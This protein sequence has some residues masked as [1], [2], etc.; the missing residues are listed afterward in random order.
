MPIFYIVQPR[1]NPLNK[2]ADPK[3]YLIAKSWDH[4]T[5]DV[6][7][8]DMVRNTSLTTNEAAAG[9]DYLF[10]SI[11]RYL[12]HG[13][14]VQLGPLGYFKTTIQSQGVEDPDDATPETIKGIKLR[15]VPGRAIREEIR[16][17]PVEIYPEK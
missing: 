11:P 15:F 14:T 7:L 12:R 6:L 1:K 8:E 3:Y 16:N 9:M 17:L 10:N 4:V 5:R 2:Q 13:L